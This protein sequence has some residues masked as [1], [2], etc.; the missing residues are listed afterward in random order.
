M[1]RLWTYTWPTSAVAH[2]SFIQVTFCNN[3]FIIIKNS[4]LNFLMC[5]IS[6]KMYKK[7]VETACNIC[8]EGILS[9]MCLLCLNQYY[10]Q[11]CKWQREVNLINC[12]FYKVNRNIRT[13]KTVAKIGWEGEGS[14]IVGWLLFCLKLL[15]IPWSCQLVCL[16]A[17][18]NLSG[19]VQIAACGNGKTTETRLMWKKSI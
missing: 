3:N 10:I 14:W 4:C 2:L 16:M 12:W 13:Y 7:Q 1:K 6:L 19:N 11:G 18:Q 8:C 5:G 9:L 15:L 17:W